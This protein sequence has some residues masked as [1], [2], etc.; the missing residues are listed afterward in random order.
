MRIDPDYTRETLVRLIQ[1]NSINPTLAVGAPGETEIA[2]FIAESL[3]ACRLTVE[4][5]IPFQAVPPSPASSR[6]PEAAA[7]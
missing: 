7:A 2:R 6:E 3:R 1:I 5:T 4:F